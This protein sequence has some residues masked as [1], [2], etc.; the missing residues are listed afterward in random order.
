MSD[1]KQVIVMRYKYLNEKGEQFSLRKG[2]LIAQACHASMAF[3]SHRIRNF[4]GS[5]GFFSPD[6]SLQL[7]PEM[8]LWING[9]FAKICVSVDSEEELLE[10]YQKAKDASLETHLITDSGRTEFGG[11]PTNTCL[12]IGPDLSSKI[13]PIT[14][15]LK[16]L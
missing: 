2:K 10:I 1:I 5:H 8:E 7:T 15:Q 14:G 11:V 9:S 16:L 13:D 4:L 12:A 3:L 6:P